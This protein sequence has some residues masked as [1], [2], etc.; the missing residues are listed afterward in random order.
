MTE[1]RVELPDELAA[2]IARRAAALGTTAEDW[3]AAVV[4]DLA[5][6]LPDETTEGPDDFIAR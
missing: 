1:V 2:E 6:D 5:A 4:Q 3:V